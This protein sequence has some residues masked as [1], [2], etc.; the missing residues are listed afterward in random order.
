LLILKGE[1]LPIRGRIAILKGRI[2]IQKG[3]IASYK[4]ANCNSPLQFTNHFWLTIKHWL[5]KNYGAK[6][7]N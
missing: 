5:L 6:I 2:T 1:L 3:R 4:R 7:V